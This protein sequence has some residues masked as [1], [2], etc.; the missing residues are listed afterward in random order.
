M[1][2]KSSSSKKLDKK[3]RNEKAEGRVIAVM[4]GTAS[5][6]NIP[7]CLDPNTYYQQPNKGDGDKNLPTQTHDLVVAI[8]GKSRAH[9]QEHGDDYKSFDA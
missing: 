7:R 3:S 1:P 9:P 4:M 8:T 2:L 6:P 5:V